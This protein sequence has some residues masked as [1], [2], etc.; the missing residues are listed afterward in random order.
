MSSK[1]LNEQDLE[2]QAARIPSMGGR[3]IGPFLRQAA[4]EVGVGQCIV[5]I[6]AW[7]GAGT[8]QMAL[9]A[10]RVTP[11]PTIHVF[12][13]FRTARHEIAKAERA[14]VRLRK[15]QNTLPLVQRHLAPFR[16]PLVFHKTRIDRAE[17]DAGP[18]GLFVDDVSKGPEKFFQ[19]LRTFGPSWIVGETI[20]VLMD[21]YYWKKAED[22]ESARRLR[23]QQDFV[24]A[25]P[26]AFEPI[27]SEHTRNTS[28]AIFRYTERLDFGAL[29]LMRSART[30]LLKR[31]F[32]GRA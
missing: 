24:T 29:P 16:V 30:G 3:E 31:L 15:G 23:V 4:S 18:I 21:Y 14:G 25:H 6:G 12:D 9:G 7:M 8:A 19:V 10:R 22:E 5:E 26:E 13:R 2:Q 20:V 11:V 32:G 17:W 1:Q 27:E 28:S